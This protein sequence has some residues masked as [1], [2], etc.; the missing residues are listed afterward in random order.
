[1]VAHGVER[2]RR[3]SKLLISAGSAICQARTLLTTSF[4]VA[5]VAMTTQV[6]LRQRTNVATQDATEVSSAILNGLSLQPSARRL[7]KTEPSW[8][9]YSLK[10]N[11]RTHAVGSKRAAQRALSLLRGG[12]IHPA[13]W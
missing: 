11:R 2:D 10:S 6:T 1:V 13:N 8:T 4:L 12:P 3:Y 9:H 7:S 5:K